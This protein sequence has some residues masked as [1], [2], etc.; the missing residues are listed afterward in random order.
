MAE[1]QS[2]ETA[3]KSRRPIFRHG[4][5]L[6][7]ES[8]SVV[9]LVAIAG[10]FVV[11]RSREAVAERFAEDW[12]RQ[13]GV[14]GDIVVQ[15]IDATGFSGSVRLGPANDPDLV[16]DRVDVDYAFI[17]PWIGGPM[18]VTPRSI[19]LT[20]PRAKLSFDGKQLHFG[21]LD[22]LIRDLLKAPKT[23]APAPDIRV[24]NGA[25]RLATPYGLV[26]IEGVLASLSE[27]RLRA[28][29]AR[30][31]PAALKGGAASVS[32]KGGALHLVGDGASLTGGLTMDIAKASA[33]DSRLTEAKAALDVF[34]LKYDLAPGAVGVASRARLRLTAARLEAAGVV[35]AGP[36]LDLNFPF[37]QATLGSS[38]T[39]R[40]DAAGQI[41]AASL[42]GPIA[43]RALTAQIRARSGTFSTGSGAPRLH[44]PLTVVATA[45]SAP[46]DLI[47]AP[48]ALSAAHA[49][50]SGQ[51][52][53][54]AATV[55][56]GQANLS[57]SGALPPRE[58][59]RI[60]A[61]FPV[62][63]QEP[64]YQSAL[65]MALERFTL[66]AP[67]VEVAIGKASSAAL[68]RPVALASASGV[69]VALT[70]SALKLGSAVTGGALVAIAGGGL[71]P[72]DLQLSAI[73][74]LG[75]EFTA[76]TALKTT[77]D[78]GP[79]KAAVVAVDGDL[80][81]GHAGFSLTT[82]HCATLTAAYL[83]F[84]ENR[85]ERP[86]AQ[87]CPLPGAP[88]ITASQG[89]WR[90]SGRLAQGKAAVPFL[91]V[92]AE[93]AAGAF[94]VHGAGGPVG[95]EIELTDAL[96]ADTT[97]P[98]R[99]HPLRV[100]GPLNLAGD[101]WR[102]TL[103]VA[104]A[105]N[106][107]LGQVSLQHDDLSG[108]GFADID[109]SRL[110]FAKGALQPADISPAA[111]LLVDAQGQAGFTGRLAWTKDQP[112]SG[113]GRLIVPGLDF[114]SPVGPV[115]GVRADVALTS[116][117]PL[118]TAPNQAATAELIDA[119]VPMRDARASFSLAEDGIHLTAASVA[120]AGGHATLAPMTLPFAKDAVVTGAIGLDDIDLNQ[121]VAL[122][123][124]AEKVK[125]DLVVDGA[126]PFEADAK[127][128]RLLKGHIATVRPGRVS[129][130]RGVLSDVE[131][132]KATA[133]VQ[134]GAKATT[135]AQAP[136][137]NAVQ[138]LVYDAL[139]NL[140][141]DSLKADV[142]SLP[143]GRLGALF[144]IQG[145][146]DPA[147]APKA[148]ISLFDAI[149]GQALSREIPLPK[150]TPV[151]LTL[152]SSLNLDELIKGV[153]S[154]FETFKSL[155]QRSRSAPVQR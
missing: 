137:T 84:G 102:G 148:E 88:L 55:L 134:A 39:G 131:S 151:D 30:L 67:G 65:A 43:A 13:H 73:S 128:F 130:D 70:P 135:I 34:G 29:D 22:P 74:L 47:G 80:R 76:Q 24:D 120:A 101:V 18:S 3:A 90:L 27:G 86:S 149:R 124:Y 17:P 127:G 58:A 10:G 122:T 25:V 142:Q 140:A 44:V 105:Q 99:F 60:A 63:G 82:S 28:L 48:I 138:E 110:V 94:A 109:A 56:S 57:A 14:E 100:R 98:L 68:T 132:G 19:R 78:F 117:A 7:L 155:H 118:V 45:G 144:S 87:A 81:Y 64:K 1:A 72:L 146:Y 91:Q 37:V 38:T 5:A 133:E 112:A 129:I 62:L 52:D 93:N 111:D 21:S 95:A 92:R 79:A 59:Q 106:R 46:L 143:S 125:A 89:A 66:S 75:G 69:H 71:P 2:A 147:V 31:A 41:A 97:D 123:S 85:V 40:F 12:L 139:E 53:T 121:L 15:R 119:F 116:L 32:A 113:A 108:A 50:F 126:L 141:V 36:S 83:D 107:A 150:G 11:I 26:Q 9:C 33:R 103:A 145:R 16:A 61:G 154:S 51:L 42:A 35:T 77:L 6:A 153:Q 23:N 136:A 115:H 49:D 4:A 20:R 54:A 114:A 96:V 8:L 104:T 152:D